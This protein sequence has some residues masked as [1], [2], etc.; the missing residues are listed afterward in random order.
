[1][2]ICFEHLAA[3]LDDLASLVEFDVNGH[4][5]QGGNGGLV[6]DQTLR[7]AQEAK[8]LLNRWRLGTGVPSE[9]AATPDL[10]SENEHEAS[11][12]NAPQGEVK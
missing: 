1:M 12:V 8:L 2:S 9:A 5:G 4:A 10:T 6:N 11:G 3:K 7:C